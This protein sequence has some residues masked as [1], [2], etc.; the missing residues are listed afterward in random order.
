MYL[1]EIYYRYRHN[2]LK[3]IVACRI[4]AAFLII[5]IRD[6]GPVLHKTIFETKS[7][8]IPDIRFSADFNYKIACSFMKSISA[9]DL[10][11]CTQYISQPAQTL[12]K[13]WET[14]LSLDKYM[15]RFTLEGL[16][17]ILLTININDNDFSLDNDKSVLTAYDPEFGPYSHSDGNSNDDLLGFIDHYGPEFT[18]SPECYFF[19]ELL[20][21]IYLKSKVMLLELQQAIA[22]KHIS[23]QITRPTFLGGLGLFGG[24]WVIA[25]GVYACLFGT[26]VLHPWG[27]IHRYCFPN[28]NSKLVRNKF[29]IIPFFSP[30]TNDPKSDDEFKA[31]ELFLKDYVV[32]VGYLETLTTMQQP[33]ASSDLAQIKSSGATFFTNPQSVYIN[34]LPTPDQVMQPQGTHNLQGNQVVNLQSTGIS[35]M[36]TYNF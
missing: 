21:K 6:D 3:S 31:L 35:G 18:Y 12:T 27:L 20:K 33:D 11:D 16:K 22:K 25:A 5:D 28:D 34:Q 23:L 7:L 2:E 15:E 13:K 10:Q 26:G 8:P 4:I 14:L 17:S 30:A 36:Q 24:V 32:N 19:R 1:Q 9:S 29:P